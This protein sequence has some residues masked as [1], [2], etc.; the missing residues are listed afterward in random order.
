MPFGKL[1][2]GPGFLGVTRL[3]VVFNA[4]SSIKWCKRFFVYL[5]KIDPI[6]STNNKL[7]DLSTRVS[8]SLV[9]GM[10]FSLFNPPH[11]SH[12]T[13]NR[14][15]FSLKWYT[16]IGIR[17]TSIFRSF[18]SNCQEKKFKKE[19]QRLF[20]VTIYSH[21]Q[22]SVTINPKNW[23]H[24]REIWRELVEMWNKLKDELVFVRKVCNVSIQFFL[25]WYYY[26]LMQCCGLCLFEII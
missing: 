9:F 5:D 16:C 4:T 1:I 24:H 25:N 15:F 6:F 3:H 11:F 2:S 23:S 14:A 10:H 26:W 22:V 13:L 18:S 21:S 20:V 12:Y 7:A 17:K 8:F 19:N